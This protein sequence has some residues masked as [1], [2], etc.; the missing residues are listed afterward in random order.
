MGHVR[1]VERDGRQLV[2][3]RF[4]EPARVATEV[5]AL[6][7]LAGDDDLPVPDL[8]EVGSGSI[9]MG[10]LPGE[11][12]DAGSAD[13]RL[14][15]LHASAALLR[16]LHDRRP[17]PGLPPAPD[18]H[19]ILRRYR[20]SGGPPL[21]LVVPPPAAP[22]FCHGDWTDANLLAVG[23]RI[24][25]IV[26]WEAA[27]VGDPVREL[28]RAAWGASLKDPRSV[29]ALVTGYG[30]DAAAVGAWFAVH[31]AELWLWFAEAG[32]PAYLAELTT[33]LERWEE[34]WT[35]SGERRPR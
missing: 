12:L 19:A 3:K 2:E 31:A 7:A 4:A 33:R 8:V 27:H 26:D 29:D 32:P 21:P 10:L 23:T 16:R 6:R 22:T 15:R 14:D 5:A 11:R 9:V 24:T 35:L 1:L 20:E 34:G 18:D 30:A 28:S 17:P 13:L 25:G